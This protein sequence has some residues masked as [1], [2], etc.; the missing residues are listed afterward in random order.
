M[1]E[2]GLA[3]RLD[4][5]LAESVLAKARLS[6]RR[7]ANHCFHAP[8][9]RLQRMVNAALRGSYFAPHRHKDPDKLEIFTILSGRVIV[10]TFDDEGGIRDHAVLSREGSGKAGTGK[11]GSE[12]WQVE[13]P[14]GTWHTLA[15]LSE[16]AV[17]YEVI[18]G[19]YDPGTHK[20]FAPWAPSEGDPEAAQAYLRDLLGRIGQA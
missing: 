19:S 14:A 7:R 15:V 13:I 20:R 6:P 8:A 11:E 5:D 10:I 12:T 2:G 3:N 1:S 9:D 4:P 17:L 16:E 18:D